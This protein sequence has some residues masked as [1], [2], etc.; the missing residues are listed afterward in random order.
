LE[1]SLADGFDPTIRDGR[2][3]LEGVELDLTD[4]KAYALYAYLQK[5]NQE[6]DSL[7]RSKLDL[8]QQIDSFQAR[9]EIT[10]RI[11][12]ELYTLERDYELRRENYDVMLRKN[13][14]TEMAERL[15]QHWQGG[16]FRILDPAHLPEKPVTPNVPFFIL[17][18]LFFGAL[19]GIITSALADYLDRSVKNVRQ[20]EALLPFPVLVTVPHA[21]KA[22]KSSKIYR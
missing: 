13:L 22:K 18:G 16:L 20:L 15:E 8:E 7:R 10:P 14:E 3:V 21:G 11:E 1:E 19:A 9:V 17:S 6:L 5:T 4:P 12:A 2:I